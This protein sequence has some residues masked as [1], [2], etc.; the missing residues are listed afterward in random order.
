M[1]I[2]FNETCIDKYTGD[3]YET[4]IVYEIE[5]ARAEEMLSNAKCVEKVKVAKKGKNKA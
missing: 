5:D 2:K 4:G 1:K 3:V